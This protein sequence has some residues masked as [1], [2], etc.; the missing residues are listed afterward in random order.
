MVMSLWPSFL[1]HPVHNETY[2]SSTITVRNKQ[3]WTS[4]QAAHIANNVLR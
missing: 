1:A 2:H 4:P 3:L